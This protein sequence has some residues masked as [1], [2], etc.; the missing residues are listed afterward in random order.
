MIAAEALGRRSREDTVRL[1]FSLGIALFPLGFALRLSISLDIACF[2]WVCI[3]FP[4]SCIICLGLDIPSL[5]PWYRFSLCGTFGLGMELGRP[6]GSWGS[7]ALFL[8]L[9]VGWSRF[10]GDNGDVK[11]VPTRFAPTLS[12]LHSLEPRFPFGFRSYPA[13]NRASRICLAAT[14]CSLSVST[15]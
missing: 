9:A 12:V 13:L 4:W 15:T 3:V 11:I 1:S 14:L 5:Q 6:R 8:R 7:H 10:T 2:P